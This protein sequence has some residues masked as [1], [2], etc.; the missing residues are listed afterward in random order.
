MELPP[1]KLER[2]L[3]GGKGVLEE[4][5]RE[6]RGGK[7]NGRVH[8]TVYRG[9]DQADGILLLQNGKE[10]IAGH[11][12]GEIAITGRDA[13]R[14]I[15]RDSLSDNCVVEVRSYDH[16][17]SH[18]NIPQLAG[19][20][21]EAKL[22]R[23]PGHGPA[24]A[25]AARGDVPGGQARR[26]PRLRRDLRGRRARGGGAEEGAHAGVQRGARARAVDSGAGGGAVQ[27]EVGA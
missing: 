6:L 1:G 22:D 16:K 10:V 5:L 20:F 19:T 17:T 13:V 26:A 11:L 2:K 21:P 23:T 9:E 4:L 27:E 18:V 7:F 3:V 14:E 24:S 25:P 8:T 12:V 15:A